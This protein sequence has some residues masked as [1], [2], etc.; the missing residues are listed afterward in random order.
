MLIRLTESF[1]V[2]LLDIRCEED[3]CNGLGVRHFTS[4]RFCDL[5]RRLPKINPRGND[6]AI[7]LWNLGLLQAVRP[8]CDCSDAAERCRCWVGSQLVQESP[9]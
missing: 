9:S 6:D 2:V 5:F 1:V 7:I 4:N 8:V 3:V